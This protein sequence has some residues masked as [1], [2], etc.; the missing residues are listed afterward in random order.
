MKVLLTGATGFVGSHVLESL[1]DRGISVIL[2]LRANSDT[3]F[4]APLLE[5]VT[6][7][8]G[9]I[10]DAE[11]LR[12]A[13]KDATHA[14]HCA[15]ATKALHPREF[16]TVNQKGTRNLVEAAN[17]WGKQIQRLVCISSAAAGHPATPDAPARE[18]DTPAPLTDYGSSKL[19]GEREV[20]QLA[21]MPYVILRPPGVYGPRDREFLKL[22]KAVKRHLLPSFGGGGQL[23]NLIYV[24]DLAE[25]TV[26]CLTHPAV[27]NKIYNVASP[28]T[29]TPRQIAVEISRLLNVWTIPM[30]LPMPFLWFVCLAQE[31]LSQITRKANVVSL[32]KYRELA[33][34]GW[35][36]DTTRLKIETG[37][38]AS[39]RLSQGLQSTLQWYMQHGWL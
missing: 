24:K 18:T 28:E 5:R 25:I 16:Y 10:S 7:V 33:A 31:V 2:L 29:V 12:R 26:E 4:I 23:L 34:P 22:F 37:L 9:S 19:A 11:S 3:Q 8:R 36:C 17:Y 32:Q 20:I 30:P 1:L 14:I 21:R 15:G 27:E 6:V 38:E 13:M 39:T 35:C